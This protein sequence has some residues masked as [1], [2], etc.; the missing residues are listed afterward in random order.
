M[1]REKAVFGT[2]REEV[3]MSKR[4]NEL[5]CVQ[6]VRSAFVY[7]EADSPRDAMDIAGEVA[8]GEL[9]DEDYWNSDEEVASVETY[10]HEIDDLDEDDRI[11]TREGEISY[12]DYADQV[13]EEEG[14][15][16]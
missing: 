14:G 2:R 6:I 10:S 13:E 3:E 5:Y 15:E 12:D 8:C 9:D 4:T 1:P 11:F 16:E 7:V